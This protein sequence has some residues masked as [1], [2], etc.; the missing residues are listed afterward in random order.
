MISFYL[1]K[2]RW[3]ELSSTPADVDS[4]STHR[5]SRIVRNLTRIPWLLE[6]QITSIHF[7]YPNCISPYEQLL[8][9]ASNI[10]THNFIRTTN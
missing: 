10:E 4:A 9:F 2:S 1:P 3:T 8:E 7:L 5:S 6:K